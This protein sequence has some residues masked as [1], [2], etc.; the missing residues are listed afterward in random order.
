M[1][2]G[3]VWGSDEGAGESGLFKVTTGREEATQTDRATQFELNIPVPE[4]QVGK[5]VCLSLSKHQAQ[6]AAH[7][8][9]SQFLAERMPKGCTHFS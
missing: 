5:N 8:R 6:K 4:A 2:T 7:S 3:Q 9:P 1:G